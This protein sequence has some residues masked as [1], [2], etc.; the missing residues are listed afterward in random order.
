MRSDW[1]T[2]VKMSATDTTFQQQSPVSSVSCWGELKSVVRSEF[3][4][5]EA[6]GRRAD[7]TFE[8]SPID[9]DGQQK[10]VHHSAAG[11]VEY[12]V[13]RDFKLKSKADAVELTCSRIS[14]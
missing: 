6:D 5:A 14:G 10:L 12:R 2:L 1:I 13:L 7:A 4:D 3:Y 11:D 9:Y 8:V